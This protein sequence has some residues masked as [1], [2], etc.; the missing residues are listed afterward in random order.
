MGQFEPEISSKNSTR[1]W[2]ALGVIL[3]CLVLLMILLIASSGRTTVSPINNNLLLMIPAAFLAGMLSFLSPCTLPLLPAYFAF[4]FQASKTNV[5]VMTL[6]FFLGLASTLTV[7]GATATALS[8]FLFQNLRMLTLVGGSLIIIFGVMSLLGFGFTGVQF[9]NRPEATVI[10]S[11]VYGATFS[12][13][14][15]ACVGPILGAILTMLATQGAGILQGAFL[16]FIYALGLGLPL[17]LISSFFSRLG[18]GTKFWK[19]LRGKGFTLNIL[20][21]DL[22]LHTTSIFSGLLLIVMGALLAS[23]KLTII[24]QMAAASNISRWVVDFEE[25]LRSLLGIK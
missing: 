20:G 6:A 19:F 21:K 11:Y 9:Q 12:L 14:W 5:V 13:G 1:N 23:G 24:T 4:S 16:A 22:Y 8:L 18:T 25:V 17:V 15:S 7:L 2:A 3:G 10:G